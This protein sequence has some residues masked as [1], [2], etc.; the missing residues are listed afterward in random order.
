MPNLTRREIALEIYRRTD[1]S[2]KQ[3]V[4]MVDLTLDS[5]IRALGKGRNVELRN[6]GI[7]RVGKR[8]ATVGR[9]PKQPENVVTIPARAVV[10]FR[11]GK[12]LAQLLRKIDLAR[13]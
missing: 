7:F 1:F 13:L 6:F 12:T 4:A 10:R 5:I 2:Q 11:A 8:K 3:I 9:N